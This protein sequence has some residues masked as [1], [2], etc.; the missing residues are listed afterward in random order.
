MYVGEILYLCQQVSISYQE[1]LTLLDDEGGRPRW[2]SPLIFDLY[3]MFN[4]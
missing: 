1:I 2:I 3:I 4:G